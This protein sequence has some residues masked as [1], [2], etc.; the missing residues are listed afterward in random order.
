MRSHTLW[1]RY[2]T[3][4][5]YIQQHQK[6][7]MKILH[8]NDLP[9][10]NSNP[11]FFLFLIFIFFTLYTVMGTYLIRLCIIFT[12][13]T[14]VGAPFNASEMPNVF[15]EIPRY[16]GPIFF[17]TTNYHKKLEEEIRSYSKK[18]RS[19]K[20]IKNYLKTCHCKIRHLFYKTRRLKSSY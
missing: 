5:T 11:I 8:S 14:A 2:V 15:M 20:K 4:A 12:L 3:V 13:H 9:L 19:A 16:S 10:T 7:P 17:H 18:S 6:L 1:Q